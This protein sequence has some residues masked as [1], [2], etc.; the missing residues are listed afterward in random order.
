[1]ITT[2]TTASTPAVRLIGGCW[3]SPA[4]TLLLRAALLDASSALPAWDEWNS[5][6]D[7]DNLD[8]GSFRLLGLLYRNLIRIGAGPSHPMMP[9]LKGI[10]RHFWTHNQLILGRKGELLRA[11]EQRGIPCLLLKGAALTLTVYQDHGVRPMDDFDLMVPRHRV[12]DAMDILEASGW[13]S[14]VHHPR[15]LP[16]SIH[17][18]SFRNAAGACIDL[19][20]RLC[21]LPVSEEFDRDLW[22]Q[23]LPVVLQGVTAAVPSWTAQF[24][25]T[26]AH[27]PQYKAVSPVR[28]LADAF[29]ILR[30]AD[31]KLDWNAIAANAPHAGAVH[32]VRGTLAFLRDH[33]DASVPPEA[34]R[35]MGKARV[36][37]QERWENFF[38]SRPTPTPWHRMPLDLSH[39][40]RCTRG[41]KWRQRLRGFRVYF[42]HANN[43]TPGQFTRHH[44]AQAKRWFRVWLPYH[45]RNLVR[46]FFPPEPGA[47][48]LLPPDTL[49]NFYESEPLGHRLLRWSRPEAS[50]AL[51]FPAGI[52]FRVELALGHLRNWKKD[53]SRHLRLTLNGTPVPHDHIKP[54]RGVLRITFPD[55][56]TSPDPD[57]H[58]ILAWSCEPKVFEHDPRTLGIPL[59]AVRVITL[60][61][62]KPTQDKVDSP[63][64]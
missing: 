48:N 3:P 25:H 6:H 28:W 59:L 40:L 34:I 36:P 33:L 20:W 50:L 23:R 12:N 5:Q 32:G 44:R 17:A 22:H 13:K 53:L 60:K 46:I 19:H 31:G 1:M 52:R 45:L 57:Q 35:L 51:K 10:Y 56:E 7:L 62:A 37:L 55:F 26:C 58:Q 42:R 54:K 47:L 15:D 49:Q 41:Q 30:H 64:R 16:L 18:C 61:Q 11:L 43:L 27:G 24:L 2:T 14:E 38:L 29:V 4:Q 8:A 63:C 39:H 21:H 9:R